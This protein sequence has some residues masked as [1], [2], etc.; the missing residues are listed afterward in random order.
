MCCWVGDVLQLAVGGTGSLVAAA[1]ETGAGVYMHACYVSVCRTQVDIITSQ[2][3]YT[4]KDAAAAV[5]TMLE[6]SCGR[7]RRGWLLLNC[8]GELCQLAAAV[9]VQLALCQ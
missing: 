8:C 2:G 1:A 6:V 5:R 7:E 4:E 3:T 9:C